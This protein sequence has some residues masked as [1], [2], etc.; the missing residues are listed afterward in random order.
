MTSPV[1]PTVPQPSPNG[2]GV[3]GA[4]SSPLL[5]ATPLTAPE[6]IDMAEATLLPGGAMGGYAG[7]RV[8]TH[9]S[10]AFKGAMEQARSH[11]FRDLL[12]PTGSETAGQAAK[13]EATK[14]ASRGTAAAARAIASKAATTAPKLLTKKAG[15]MALSR[16][17]LAPIPLVGPI[18]TGAT[19]L[20]DKDT[21]NL[22]NGLISS[23][24]GVGFAPDG[25]APPS[26]PRTHF[27]PLTSDGNRDPQIERIDQGM[28]QTNTAALNYPPDDVWP[29]QPAITTTPDF[30]G[31]IAAVNKLGPKAS[32]IA[33]SIRTVSNSLT[34]E[35]AG[36][37]ATALPGKL[38]PL[39]D[40]LDEYRNTV[41]PAAS[42]AI[43]HVTA[44]SNDFYQNF[45]AINNRN[46]SEIANSTSGLIPF[47]ANRVNT[48][49]MD[50]SVAS[51]K[52]AAAEIN[53]HNA[54]VSSAFS[55]WSVPAASTARLAGAA[56]VSTVERGQPGTAT[57]PPPAAAAPAPT[58]STPTQEP[59]TPLD[60]LLSG[61][62]N[63]MP[64]M[65]TP[66]MPNLGGIPMSPMS[67]TPP[68]GPDPGM[69]DPTAGAEH[70]DE[71]DKDLDDDHKPDDKPQDERPEDENPEEG[72]TAA[73]PP[74]G[75]PAAVTPPPGADRT[76]RIGN[77]DYMFN[78]PRI[79]AS[80][81]DTVEA[82][83]AGP[84]VPIPQVLADNGF[85]VPPVGQPIGDRV[86][87]LNVA[88][89]GQIIVSDNGAN[90][91]WYMGNAEA[92]TEQGE[93]KP[94]SEVMSLVGANDGIFSIPEP[95]TPV[96]DP[97]ATPI[98]PG[99]TSTSPPV[100]TTSDIP[101][102]PT[103][104]PQPGPAQSPGN[105]PFP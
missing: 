31:T 95:G 6:S 79:A 26:P 33:D 5:T 64:Q 56:P 22:V 43:N 97:T 75:G 78:S 46:R 86:D 18:L 52:A 82:A 20:F 28:N 25:D 92:L 34:R 2:P 50:D 30:S 10:A 45:R 44:K 35:S 77:K 13:K 81:R 47:T 96:I 66:S 15:L 57:P 83:A 53:K 36:N 62:P 99:S 80:I 17:A 54:A 19:W 14:A 27:L 91:A 72:P 73:G 94:V 104:Q 100:V 21:R 98:E 12:A 37:F 16:V 85:T 102:A 105:Q 103:D 87:S 93:I 90:M 38:G 76:V 61:L 29:A 84:G 40:A 101:P 7:L 89:P 70:L 3:G 51:A 9:Q 74:A 39:A 63:T 69:V 11:S 55:N 71:H 65:P 24:G 42:T 1:D 59:R 88:E 49:A 8:A 60:S 4:A 58:T 67:A 32:A 23:V 68:V 48:G 41:L